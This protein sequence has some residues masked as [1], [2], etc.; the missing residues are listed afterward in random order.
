[1]SLYEN[2]LWLKS[3]D[4][5]VPHDIEIPDEPVRY[6]FKKNVERF[7]DK[8]YLLFN[9]N[10]LSYAVVNELA[11][12]LA[13]ALLQ[14]GAK[15]GDRIAFLMPNIPEYVV[16]IQAGY[17][18]GTLNVGLNPLYTVSELKPQINDCGASIIIVY[19]RLAPKALALQMDEDCTL[20]KVIVVTPRGEAKVV[21]TDVL[22][23]FESLVGSSLSEEPGVEVI[24]E[25]MAMLQYTG[26]TT[27]VSKA[28]VLTNRNIMAM[29][30]QHGTW[31]G[32]ACPPDEMRNLCVIPLFHVYGWNTS[33][34]MTLL[35]GGTIILVSKPDPDLIL[36]NI[37]RHEPTIWSTIPRFVRELMDHP[38]ILDSKIGKLQGLL[39]GGAPLLD[40]D[41][42]RFKSLTDAAILEGYGSSETTNILTI[43]P[44]KHSKTG[45][46][47]LPLPNTILKIVDVETGRVEMP[48]GES[49]EIVAKGPQIMGQ[50]WNSPMETEFA[51]TDDG[52]LYTG[53]IG[54]MDEDGFFFIVDRK[55]D[56]I[57]RSGFNVYPRE[58]DEVIYQLPNIQESC[59]VGVPHDITGETVKVFVVLKPGT[60]LTVYEIREFCRRNLA[61]YK[62]PEFVEFVDEIP[63]TGI[64]KFD[65]NAL[66]IRP[67]LK[68]LLFI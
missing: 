14:L 37:N 21:G 48:V 16:A 26:G 24:A 34:N 43:N 41:I 42:N 56:L 23:D 33:V 11:C 2:R 25:D 10:S 52:Y 53:D 46:V 17:K 66:R 38:R 29:C 61:A 51:F 5:E 47:G 57:I 8:P 36:Y 6:F 31:M 19:S 45:S 4:L 40:Q 44:V 20:K 9:E 64:G 3:Y 18:A 68:P 39:C 67:D 49:G 65:R 55:K 13:N 12:R 32:E 27:G 59:T 28:C 54:Y 15:K 63:K 7:P 35:G 22:F 62:V 58:I 60:R 30:R 1:M 50:Y